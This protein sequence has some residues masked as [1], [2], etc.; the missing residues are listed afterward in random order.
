MLNRGQKRILALALAGFGGMLAS[1]HCWAVD[2]QFNASV[3]TD[4]NTAGN[5]TPNTLPGANTVDNYFVQTGLTSAYSAGNVAVHGVV[6]GDDST[7]SLNMTAGHLT[8]TGGGNS[9]AVGRS[10]NIDPSLRGGGTVNLSGTAILEIGG[11]DPVVGARDHGVL[12]VGGSSQVFPTT[13]GGTYWRLGNYG[14]SFDA[15]LLGNGLLNVHN[16]GS[17][18][19]NVIFLGDNDS[20]GELR[21]SDNGSVV[22]T[23]NL[24]ARPAGTFTQGSATVRMTGSHATLQAHGLESASDPS[25]IKTLYRFDADAGGVSKITLTDAINIT[26]NNLAVNLNGFVVPAQGMLLFDGDQAL[27]GN[28][29]FGTFDSLTVNGVLNPSNYSVTYNQ[30]LGDISLTLVP[31]P[32]S[33]A[34]LAIGATLLIGRRRQ[35]FAKI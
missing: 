5:W 8:V 28:R 19:A 33:L 1:S 29:I 11:S 18:R 25:E 30:A 27:A 26:H 12:D 22:L 20:T 4:F 32:A 21:V 6:V 10:L 13:V 31:E 23:D 34:A 17:F 35:S 14:P 9:F 16:N 15:G 7:G 24:N 3:G 2:N